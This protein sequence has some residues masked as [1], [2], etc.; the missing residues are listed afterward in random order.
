MEPMSVRRASWVAH[1]ES[2]RDSDLTLANYCRRYAL[3]CSTFVAW[4]KR[5]AADVRSCPSRLQASPPPDLMQK[6]C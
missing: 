5:S 2:W 4:I 1:V 3:T 6:K